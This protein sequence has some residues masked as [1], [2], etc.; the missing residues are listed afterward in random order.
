MKKL[1]IHM[2]IFYHS[3]IQSYRYTILTFCT[4]ST[5]RSMKSLKFYSFTDG[6]TDQ[7]VKLVNIP[8][9]MLRK[10]IKWQRKDTTI[11]RYIIMKSLENMYTISGG[12]MYKE[13]QNKM[14]T[15]WLSLTEPIYCEGLKW[16]DFIK[17]ETLVQVWPCSLV[18][19]IANYVQL[20]MYRD[21]W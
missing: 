15:E 12:N 7:R 11:F 9:L 13:K 5:M 1:N 17:I 21:I 4:Y 16:K 14:T 19:V 8:Y 2:P 6:K 20:M 18:V 3:T 10:G